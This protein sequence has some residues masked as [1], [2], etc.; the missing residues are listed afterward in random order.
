M[1]REK[2]WSILALCAAFGLGAVAGGFGMRAHVFHGFA[3]RLHGPPG[4]ARM[5]FRLEA[6]S[7]ELDLSADQKEKIRKIFEAHEEERRAAFERCAPDQRALMDKVEGE[8]RAVLTP[9]QQKKHEAMLAEMGKRRR[10]GP[11]PPPPPPPEP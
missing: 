2:L 7:R 11:P 5:E 6:M 1:R 10:G 3:D 8:I 4:R 9:E